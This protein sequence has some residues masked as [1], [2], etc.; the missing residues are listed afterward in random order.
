MGYISSTKKRGVKR[1]VN[2]EKEG[3]NVLPSE[4]G[5]QGCPL[6]HKRTLN[7]MQAI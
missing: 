5:C 3:K 6:H 4:S 1:G 7:S 2:N